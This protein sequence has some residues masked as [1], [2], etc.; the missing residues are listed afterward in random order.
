MAAVPPRECPSISF[1]NFDDAVV[2]RPQWEETDVLEVTGS[3]KALGR[4]A[5]IFLQI[6]LLDQARNEFIFASQGG[7]GGV[8]YLSEEL[9]LNT[10]GSLLWQ[11]LGT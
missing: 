11:H 7:Q 4:F 10:P 3:T 8:S 6:A 2:T 5:E 1:S 9:T